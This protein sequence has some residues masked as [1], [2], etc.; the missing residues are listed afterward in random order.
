MERMHLA[1]KLA[2]FYIVNHVTVLRTVLRTLVK[3]N[4]EWIAASI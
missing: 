2:C 1:V 3:R 4:Y